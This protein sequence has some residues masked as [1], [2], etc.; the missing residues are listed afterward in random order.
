[1]TFAFK[2]TPSQAS[3]ENPIHIHQSVA[4]QSLSARIDEKV[5]QEMDC[6]VTP[7][8]QTSEIKT[9][10]TADHPTSSCL[11]ELF[12]KTVLLCISM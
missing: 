9:R 4:S 12:A 10:K 8:G 11:K 3:L 6:N 1:M 2:T 7:T 5:S